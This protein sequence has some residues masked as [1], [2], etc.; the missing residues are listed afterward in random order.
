MK[1]LQRVTSRTTV[2][3]KYQQ[4]TDKP[5]DRQNYCAVHASAYMLVRNKNEHVS[6]Q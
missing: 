3:T 6:F 4:W 2:S 5:K 1:A